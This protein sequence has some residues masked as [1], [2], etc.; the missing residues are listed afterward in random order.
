MRTTAAIIRLPLQRAPVKLDDGPATIAFI[1]SEIRRS[2][3]SYKDLAER[4]GV[5]F[6]T[7]SNIACGDTKLPR[8]STVVKIALALGW[9]IY[10]Q[11]R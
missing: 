9:S 10:A 1:A 6:A 8:L 7:I 2:H 3:L 4:S 11:D 5:C